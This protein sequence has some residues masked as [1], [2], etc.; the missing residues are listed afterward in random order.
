MP[1]ETLLLVEDDTNLTAINREYFEI[2][3]YRVLSAVTLAAAAH[4]LECEPVDLILMD[5][6]MPDGSGLD[7]IRKIREK[8]E[9]GVAVIYLTGRTDN[10]DI[11][12]GL[13]NGGDDYVTK[14][15]NF[16]VLHARINIQ[17]QKAKAAHRSRFVR[18]P[19]ELDTIASQALLSGVDMMLMPKEFSV[20]CLLVQNEGKTLSKEEIY[21]A[22]WKQPMN[23]DDTAV[24]TAISRLR[25]KLEACGLGIEVSRGEGYRFR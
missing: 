11:L 21:E 7:F 4:I 22:V 3:G 14:P 19:L 8:G 12:E 24:K 18:G 23:A 17:L 2:V 6:N 16:G 1:N 13:T 20:L 5:I 15:Y 25:G 9:S 10:A